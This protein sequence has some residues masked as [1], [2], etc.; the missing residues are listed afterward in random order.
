VGLE[1]DIRHLAPTP[2]G[3]TMP[4]TSHLR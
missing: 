3:Q 1:I 2:V 4:R